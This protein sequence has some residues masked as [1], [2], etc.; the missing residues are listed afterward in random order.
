MTSPVAGLPGVRNRFSAARQSQC[1][2]KTA[3][4]RFF[5][6][7]L[8]SFENSILITDGEPELLTDPEAKAE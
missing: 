8:S 2:W 4:L 1:A 6:L 3:C 5:R 7:G